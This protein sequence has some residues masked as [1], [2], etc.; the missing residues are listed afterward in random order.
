VTATRKLEDCEEVVTVKT[1]VVIGVLSEINKPRIP[2]LKQVLGAAKKPNEEIRIADLG[3][4][5]EDI[6][7]KAVRKSV[8]GFVMH[9]KNVIFKESS[10]A[11]RVAKLKAS[12]ASEG[13]C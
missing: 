11:D 9:R 13:L 7:P 10:A 1:P 4:K 8:K 3:L 2:S 5:P 12:L 6:Q